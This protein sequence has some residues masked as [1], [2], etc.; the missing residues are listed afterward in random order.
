[1]SYHPI[2]IKKGVTSGK[3]IRYYLGTR[4]VPGSMPA[5]LGRRF[6][7]TIFLRL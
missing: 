7:D 6:K 2:T 5:P 3:K 4:L 1:M